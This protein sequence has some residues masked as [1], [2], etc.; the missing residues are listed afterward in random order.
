MADYCTI[1]EVKAMMPESPLSSTTDV[2]I[3]AAIGYFITAASRMIDR[4]VGQ[5]PNYFY[6]SS[7]EV[8]RY[9]DGVGDELDLMID[10]CVLLS[11]VAVSESGGISS[12]DYTIWVADVDYITIPYNATPIYGL[13]LN[14]DGGK[15]GWTNHKKA[16]KVTGVFGYSLTPPEDVKHACITQTVRWFMRAKQ[17]FMDAGA[18]GQQG[19]MTFGTAIDKDVALILDP[20]RTRSMIR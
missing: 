6:P 16:V 17:A 9:Y 8:S 19:S 15:T 7:D 20:Y 3:E 2:D 12:S 14:R 18:G 5:Y 13:R 4:Y 10:D 11:S 1:A